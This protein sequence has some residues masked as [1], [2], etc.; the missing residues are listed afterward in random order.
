M[1]DTIR[2]YDG[3]PMEDLVS[4]KINWVAAKQG[5]FLNRPSIIG[6]AIIPHD[7][8]DL[9]AIPKDWEDGYFQYTYGQLPAEMIAQA[10]DWFRRV[11]RERHSEAELLIMYN[12]K[13]DPQVKFFVPP[14][15]CTTASVSS[16]YDPTHFARGWQPIGSIHSHCDFNAFHSGTDTGDA[17]EFDG[18]HITIG[19]VNSANPS[20]DAMISMNKI[21]WSIDINRV[22][23]LSLL[24]EIVAPE[25]WDRY[26]LGKS[27]DNATIKATYAALQ[28]ATRSRKTV[29]AFTP[30]AKGWQQS[31]HT[32]WGAW[33]GYSREPA[34][35]T[36]Y[37]KYTPPS[38][39][40]SD[41]IKHDIKYD[42]NFLSVEERSAASTLYY[43]ID[44]LD[45]LGMS[46][47]E[48]VTEDAFW[49]ASLVEDDDDNPD[50]LDLLLGPGELAQID[51]D[52]L[53]VEELDNALRN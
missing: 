26:V 27:D 41:Q 46:L 18:L 53:L 36:E 40:L 4:D 45:S 21:N 35:P 44:R 8:P 1:S 38:H 5:Y 50:Q 7:E 42:P 9:P 30:P 10:H 31:N 25:W 11:F 23:D 52:A 39:R 3:E 15:V 13:T 20:F 12:P 49:G 14:Q 2:L 51:A 34:K 6:T 33:Q 43:V 16:A 22:A 24:N 37:K 17:A 47:S 48:L 32:E 29:Y 28:P 19:H